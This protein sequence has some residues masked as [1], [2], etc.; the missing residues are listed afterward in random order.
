MNSSEDRSTA[1][2]EAFEHVWATLN[3]ARLLV[4]AKLQWLT[5]ED[6]NI[7]IDQ[8]LHEMPLYEEDEDLEESLRQ[9]LTAERRRATITQ[10]ADGP[11]ALREWQ[12]DRY[13]FDVERQRR[14]KAVG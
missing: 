2:A 13:A 9:W 3:R 8:A 6:I 4:P 7:V 10:Q 11:A 12:L 14:K 5:E 1:H